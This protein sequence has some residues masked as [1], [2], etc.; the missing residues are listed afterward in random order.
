MLKT[1]KD[2]HVLWLGLSFSGL[3]SDIHRLELDHTDTEDCCL[4][5]CSG[6]FFIS[7]TLLL[8]WLT[9]GCTW[10]LELNG[11]VSH[12]C[13][14]RECLAS[15]HDATEML[16]IPP[17]LPSLGA[18]ETTTVLSSVSLDPLT[19]GPASLSALL[20]PPYVLTNKTGPYIARH[21]LMALWWCVSGSDFSSPRSRSCSP[22]NQCLAGGSTTSLSSEDENTSV[23]KTGKI[24][25]T[26]NIFSNTIVKLHLNKSDIWIL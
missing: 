2:T 13:K 15:S 1:Q 7:E 4:H 11:N 6:S 12:W 10:K 16:G 25:W 26:T 3:F 23:L 17:T 9:V 22:S 5:A 14:E 21:A 18:P 19:V 20:L 24:L 8:T